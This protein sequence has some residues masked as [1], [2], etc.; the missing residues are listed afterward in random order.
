[1]KRSTDRI[2]TTHVGSLIRPQAL[3]SRIAQAERDVEPGGEGDSGEARPQRQLEL[4][5]VMHAEDG[6]GLPHD[7]EPAQT[8]QPVEPHVLARML[9][10]RRRAGEHAGSLPAS[11]AGR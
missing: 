1:M 7:R 8:H 6:R 4:E 2:L 10:L 3:G 11:A 5:A 9:Q